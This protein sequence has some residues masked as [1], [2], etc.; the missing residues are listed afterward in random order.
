M[1]GSVDFPSV[2]PPFPC[3]P[4]PISFV[5]H[6]D[7]QVLSITSSLFLLIA[8]RINS[9]C[10]Y[11]PTPVLSGT[12]RRL[13]YGGCLAA[14]TVTSFLRD[15]I[16][17]VRYWIDLRLTPTDMPGPRSITLCSS[18]TTSLDEP[19]DELVSRYFH[20]RGLEFD[21]AL[22]HSPPTNQV[23]V[24]RSSRFIL[25]RSISRL[26]STGKQRIIVFDFAPDHYLPLWSS[27][28]WHAQWSTLHVVFYFMLVCILRTIQGRH[29]RTRSA[30]QRSEL[31]LDRSCTFAMHNSAPYIA[32]S[33][34]YRNGEPYLC[35]WSNSKSFQRR[36][37]HLFG[38]YLH[39]PLYLESY[40]SH[41][42]SDVDQRE[43]SRNL[44][45]RRHQILL[46]LPI[47]SKPLG[48]S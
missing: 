20:N 3:Y 12:G 11:M 46:G 6:P 25:Y 14:V 28:Y 42:L 18:V 15:L 34:Q 1:T 30:I 29:R 7:M 2:S 44:R 39:W 16:L 36:P 23:L 19:D 33:G 35:F 47:C 4:V 41:T 38:K 24:S 10:Q 31:E 27:L 22:S 5:C 8:P 9:T 43:F 40:H 45:P 32:Y 26:P 17:P 13:C 37:C 48:N 21:S